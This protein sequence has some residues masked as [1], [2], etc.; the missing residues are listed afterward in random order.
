MKVN[1]ISGVSEEEAATSRAFGLGPASCYAAE[2]GA[3][4][5]GQVVGLGKGSFGLAHQVP[6]VVPS[7]MRY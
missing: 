4:L 5:P 7:I 2:Q 1:R 3:S 6:T